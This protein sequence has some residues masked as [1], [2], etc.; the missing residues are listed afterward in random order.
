M[1]RIAWLIATICLSSPAFADP[2]AVVIEE[3]KRHFLSGVA[4]F[5][6]TELAEALAEFEASYRLN[7]VAGVLNNIA[8]AQRGLGRY[9]ESI[10]SFRRYLAGARPGSIP[11]GR[12][13]EIERIVAEMQSHLPP[14]SS[15]LEP[16]PT[17][18]PPVAVAQPPA[19]AASPRAVAPASPVVM[20]APSAVT[21]APPAAAPPPPF[22]SSRARRF[23]R[24]RHGI[25]A[26]ALGAL[27]MGALVASA[28]TGGLAM[29]TRHTY[30]G[31]CDGAH[32]D[33]TTY[34]SGRRLAITT[35]ALLGLAFAA[36]VA[37]VGVS[38]A[39]AK[40]AVVP[41][42][43]RAGGAMVVAGSF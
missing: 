3:A 9:R 32:C 5:Q 18:T 35:D 40:L 43:D 34:D 8:L 30:D 27:T 20:P 42:V 38:V 36:G 24:S 14:P 25:A 17:P 10:E 16:R 21:S 28:A 19:L 33:P 31:N 23:F 22:A 13:L 4:L 39:G 1:K 41:A 29:Q 37:T 2:P 6:K 15:P 12:R 26:V 7:P 11:A